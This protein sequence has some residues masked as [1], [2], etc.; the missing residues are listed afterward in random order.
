MNQSRRGSWLGRYVRGVVGVLN[1]SCREHAELLSRQLDQ[2]LEPGQALGL[3]LHLCVCRGCRAFGASLRRLRSLTST[4]RDELERGEGM[5]EAVREKISRS[6][7]EKQ[8]K[9]V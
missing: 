6:I 8:Q 1:M 3:K 4:L 2:R 5:P 7:I 9:E